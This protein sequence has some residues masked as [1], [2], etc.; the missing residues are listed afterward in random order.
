MCIDMGQADASLYRKP[1][2][3]QFQ[4]AWLRAIDLAASEMGYTN[5]MDVPDAELDSLKSTARR[6]Q[7]E[8]G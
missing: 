6:I 3:A 2:C 7:S 1:S 4:M 8:G 5:F